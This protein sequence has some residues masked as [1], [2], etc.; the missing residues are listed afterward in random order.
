M[1][2]ETDILERKIAKRT[3]MQGS[4]LVSTSANKKCD[5]YILYNGEMYQIDR[6]LWSQKNGRIPEKAWLKR[7]CDTDRCVLPEHRVLM[8]SGSWKKM[9]D[10]GHCAQGHAK[11]QENTY[12]SKQGRTRCRD[13]DKAV[14]RKINARKKAAKNLTC[15]ECGKHITEPKR[16]IVCGDEC[17]YKRFLKTKRKP[18]P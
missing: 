4:C 3:E 17:A 11:T 14:M 10:D 9:S 15:Q 1:A 18:K 2:Q 5:G 7:I 6:L 13:C 8:P 12:T 16:T